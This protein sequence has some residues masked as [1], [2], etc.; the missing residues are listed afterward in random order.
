MAMEDTR[1]MLI[2]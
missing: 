2:V 1:H